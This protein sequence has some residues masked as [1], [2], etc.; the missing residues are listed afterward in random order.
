MVGKHK[1]VNMA[2]KERGSRSDMVMGKGA[3]VDSTESG[4]QIMEFALYHILEEK[5][6]R[7]F[8]HDNKFRLCS[9]RDSCS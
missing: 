2:S 4:G 5:L 9:N 8:E 7:D 1:I 6:L 3:Y